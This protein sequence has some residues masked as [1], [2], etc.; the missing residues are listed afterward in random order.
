MTSLRPSNTDVTARVLPDLSPAFAYDARRRPSQR[1]VR[2]IHSTDRVRMCA[3]SSRPAFRNSIADGDQAE[4]PGR[5]TATASDLNPESLN[6]AQ[7]LGDGIV[8]RSSSNRFPEALSAEAS[9]LPS[10]P[11]TGRTVRRPS[12]LTAT[13]T[14]TFDEV[15]KNVRSEDSQE[16]HF[17][18]DFPRHSNKWYILRCDEH[19]MNF[20][21]YPLSSAGCHIDSEVHGHIPR[22]CENS[23]LQLGVLVLGCTSELAESSNEAYKE[24]LQGGYKPKQGNIKKVRRKRKRKTGRVPK[25]GSAVEKVDHYGPGPAGLF[26]PFEGIVN[27]IPGKVYQ[28]AQP[29]PGS[30]EPQWFLVVCLPLRNW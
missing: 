3:E 12:S 21:E 26:K 27:P 9:S 22:T 14:I 24:A 18:V 25:Y 10:T 29:K 28:G 19:D 5:N 15:Y 11:Q 8:G 7:G 6:S 20:G 17:I 23:I 1:L 4:S 2:L 16:K 30:M 13:R